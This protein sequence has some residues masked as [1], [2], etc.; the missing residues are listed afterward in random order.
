M[1]YKLAQGNDQL[2]PANGHLETSY[3][4]KTKLSSG[5]LS[6]LWYPKQWGNWKIVVYVSFNELQPHALLWM[7]VIMSL[8]YEI[9]YFKINLYFPSVLFIC[10]SDL[11][12]PHKAH[13]IYSVCNNQIIYYWK[14]IVFT[15][16]YI[17]GLWLHKQSMVC[18]PEQGSSLYCLWADT[19]VPCDL[20]Q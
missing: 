8:Y 16:V 1:V 7:T 13:H 6:S 18:S 5:A 15:R 10:S 12:K 11:I 19:R 20:N 3:Y 4:L 9:S 2:G 14:V 17:Q